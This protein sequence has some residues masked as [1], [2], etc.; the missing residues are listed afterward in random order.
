MVLG[1]AKLD[2]LNQAGKYHAKL[3]KDSPWKVNSAMLDFFQ[4]EYNIAR[5][6]AGS[7]RNS[8]TDFSFP[9]A[10]HPP[11]LDLIEDRPTTKYR[12]KKNPSPRFIPFYKRKTSL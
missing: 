8:I 4:P 12:K 2:E 5:A 6:R 10:R 1:D 7:V 11:S 9:T 3:V